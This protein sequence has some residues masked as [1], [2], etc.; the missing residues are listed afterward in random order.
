MDRKLYYGQD[1]EF[2]K[3]ADQVIDE[4]ASGHGQYYDAEELA[5]ISDYFAINNMPDKMQMVVEYGL[6]LHLYYH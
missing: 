1:A 2:R 3:R 5:D 4:I 6:H